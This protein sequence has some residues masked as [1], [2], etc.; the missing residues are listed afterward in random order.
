VAKSDE[1]VIHAGRR[2]EAFLADPEIKEAFDRIATRY[3]AELREAKDTDVILRLHA[4][5]Q[6]IEDVQ[7]ELRAA[8]DTGTRASIERDQREKREAQQQTRPPRTR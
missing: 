2:I 5:F 6:V 1:E 4:K 3:V 7:R 8:K